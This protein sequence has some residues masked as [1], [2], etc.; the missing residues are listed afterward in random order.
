MKFEVPKLWAEQTCVILAGGP[1]LRSQDLSLLSNHHPWPKI[2][3]I[4]DSWKLRPYANVLYFCDA[5]WWRRQIAENAFSTDGVRFHDLI[6][7]GYW[8]HGGEGFTDHPQVRQLPFTGQV[9]L[10]TNPGG[11]RS[12]S[13]SGY[14]AI[15]LAYLFGAKRIILLGYDMQ[16][17]GG[18]THWHDRSGEPPASYFGNVLQHE[19]LPLFSHLVAPLKEAGV[20]VINSTPGSALTCWP[21][22]DLEEALSVSC[23]GAQLPGSA[24]STVAV[25]G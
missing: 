22:M 14:Q 18:R 13:N 7:K 8:V 6:Y 3:A 25:C 4:N 17:I 9:G 11:L 19:F 12:G 24:G 2:I 21:Q 20:E 16:C 23:S 15:N 1:S 10:E 5:A